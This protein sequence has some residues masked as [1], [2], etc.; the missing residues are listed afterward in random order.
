M[1]RAPLWF[2]VLDCLQ[3]SLYLLPVN[4]GTPA[5]LRQ[6]TEPK[7]ILILTSLS[8]VVVSPH[9]LHATTNF[10]KTR[11]H[12]AFLNFTLDLVDSP[13]I[14]DPKWPLDR[15]SRTRRTTWSLVRWLRGTKGVL[16]VFHWIRS[17]S[18]KYA[19]RQTISKFIKQ[20]HVYILPIN[21]MNIWI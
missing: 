19:Q 12:Q 9:R 6:P 13:K 11:K 10:L 21:C 5:S 1:A 7:E 18:G 2:Y 15:L 4:K 14:W 20:N 3:T 8:E 17:N 16:Y